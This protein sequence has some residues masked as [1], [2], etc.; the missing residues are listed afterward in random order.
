MIGLQ[1]GVVDLVPHDTHWKELFNEEKTRL[2]N[3]LGDVALG[4]EHIGSTAISGL[5]A[6]PVIDI[7][8]GIA[9]M[10]QHEQAKSLL[11][12]AGWIWRPKF[13][14]PAV[15]LVFAKGTDEVRTHYLH[16]MQ[17]QGTS[18]NEKISFR[19]YL[20][21]HDAER[22]EYEDLKR[23]AMG[24]H[25]DDRKAYTAQKDEFVARIISEAMVH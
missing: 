7:A 12:S 4:I 20:T 13:G 9:D 5:A 8:V 17:F 22:Q 19:D 14:D 25:A 23:R 10:S 3:A 21:S 16:L 15:H 24:E 1:R 6:K 18:W 2:E 11:E